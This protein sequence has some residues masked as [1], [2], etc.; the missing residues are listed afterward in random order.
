MCFDCFK[1]KIELKVQHLLEFLVD[2]NY[3]ASTSS[4]SASR[5]AESTKIQSA[6]N[7]QH[8]PVPEL[9]TTEPSNGKFSV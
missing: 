1:G 8:K 3:T 4:P 6:Q 2:N 9:N 5:P 7:R